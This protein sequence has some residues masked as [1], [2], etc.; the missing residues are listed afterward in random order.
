[1]PVLKV[2]ILEVGGTNESQHIRLDMTMARQA[3][4]YAAILIDS[5]SDGFKEDFFQGDQRKHSKRCRAY[6]SP[7]PMTKILWNTIVLLVVEFVAS[8]LPLVA[9]V[10][11]TYTGPYDVKIG[12]AHV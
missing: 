9:G 11:M 4:F 5:Y 8:G 2:T 12:R 7:K 6:R 1:M 3:L 10:G